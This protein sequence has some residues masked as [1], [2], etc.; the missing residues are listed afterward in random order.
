MGMAPCVNIATRTLREHSNAIEGGCK[1][2]YGDAPGTLTVTFREHSN[3]IEG[4]CKYCYGD[5]PGTL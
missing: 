3:A 2:C 4:G 5:A 1:Y